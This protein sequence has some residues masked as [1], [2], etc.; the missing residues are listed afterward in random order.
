MH[1]AAAQP[2]SVDVRDAS[3][4]ADGASPR[5]ASPRITSPILAT[6]A[7]LALPLTIYVSLIIFFQG[8]NKPG[9]GFIAGVLAAAAGVIALLAFGLDRAMKFK[10]WHVPVQ[11]VAVL[12][13]SGP[14]AAIITLIVGVAFWFVAR[15]ETYSTFKWWKMACVGLI[16]SVMTGT[17]PFLLGP[18]G[19]GSG[20]FM[21]HVVWHI[22]YPIWGDDHVPTAGF[23]D[24]GVYLIVAGTLMT[25]FVELGQENA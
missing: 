8:H 3:A 15:G 1:D 2:V 22:H 6:V 17:L 9:G 11:A 14:S 16:I 4:S 25:M 24:L 10:L 21:D 20:S 13:L 18:D 5:A 19:A 23:F 12:P 7:R